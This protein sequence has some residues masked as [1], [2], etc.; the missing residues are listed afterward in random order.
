MGNLSLDA[1]RIMRVGCSSIGINDLFEDQIVLF[2]DC[3][4]LGCIN[5]TGTL[6][7]IAMS[8]FMVSVEIVQGIF[9]SKA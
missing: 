8:S 3:F 1:A 7:T 4:L 6:L 5:G 2:F 9:F